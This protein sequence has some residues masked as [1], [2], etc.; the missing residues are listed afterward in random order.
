MRPTAPSPRPS[1]IGWERVSEGRVRAHCA[2]LESKVELVQSNA[3]PDVSRNIEVFALTN[4]WIA[5]LKSA[6]QFIRRGRSDD[7]FGRVTDCR[8]QAALLPPLETNDWRILAKS[9]APDWRLAN[10]EPQT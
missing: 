4:R 10:S 2:Q 5:F 6:V 7:E 9:A 3:P 1:P 8:L